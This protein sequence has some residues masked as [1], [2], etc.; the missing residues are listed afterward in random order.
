MLLN[1]TLFEI[2]YGFRRAQTYIFFTILFLLTFLFMTTDIIQIG[3][4]TGK[5]MKNAP[6]VI[7]QTVMIM[8]I[9]GMTMTSGLVG[10]AVLRDFEFK[11]HELLYTTP[12]KKTD[13][14]VGRFLGAYCVSLFVYSGIVFGIVLGSFMPWL[15]ADKIAPFRFDAYTQPFINYVIPNVFFASAL[16][17]MVGIF[18][19]NMLAVY[20]QGMVLL[21]GYTIS[22][23]LLSDIQN[24]TIVNFSDPFGIAATRLVTRYWTVIEQNSLVMPLSGDFLYNRLVW[25]GVGVLLFIA[26]LYAFEYSAKPLQFWIRKPKSS[27]ANASANDEERDEKFTPLSIPKAA[28]NE[29]FG[30]RVQQFLSQVKFH[31]LA[32]VKGR[33]F[34]IICLIAMLNLGANAWSAD[35]FFGTTVYPLT[36]IMMDVLVANVL[37]LLI[38]VMSIST[39]EVVW[40]ERNINI[41]QTTDALNIP[42][43]MAM[44]SKICSVILAQI[45]VCVVIVLAGML[46]QTL[47]GYTNY[48]ILLYA[49]FIVMQV[50]P[51]LVQ[52]T[53]LAFF[54]Q[55]II[56]NKFVANIVAVLVFISIPVMAGGLRWNHNLYL[57]GGSPEFLYSDMNG[58]GHWLAPTFWFGLYWTG[59]ALLL[60]C[61]AY[62]F[63]MRGTAS[64]WQERLQ[65]ARSRITPRFSALAASILVVTL[66]TGGYIF[67]NTNILNAYKT[68]N[69][70]R[71]LSAEFEKKY[72]RYEGA[73][74]P[75]I[76]GAKMN[77]EIFPETRIVIANGEYTLVNKTERPI[78]SLYVQ[79]IGDNAIKVLSLTPSRANTLVLGDTASASGAFRIYKLQEPLQPNDTMR[80]AFTMKHEERGFQNSGS[81]TNIVNNGTF[82]NSFAFPHIGYTSDLEIGDEDERKKEGLAPRPRMASIDDPKARMNTYIS[83][84]ADW[85]TFE[86]T[87]STSPDQIAIA[88][89]YLQKEWQEN[90]RRYFQ[91]CMDATIL[92]F[93]SFLSAR[94]EIAKDV[95]KDPQ[96]KQQDVAIEIYYH[97]GH[98]YN[99]Q[100]MIDGVKKSLTYYTKNF[101][102][103]QHRQMRILEFP[104]YDRFAQ[105][106]PNTIP[107]SEAIGFIARVNDPEEDIDY[108]FYVTAHEVGH[109][110][111]AHQVIGANVQGATLMSESLAEY[112]AL[113]VMEH[114]Y[115]R[116]VMQKFLRYDLDRYLRGRSTEQIK[117]Q[118]LMFAENQAYIHYNKGSLVMY[119]LKDYIGEDSLNAALARYI[120]K[121]AFQNAPYTTAREFVAEI[122]T[123]VPDSLQ[124]MVSDMF[125]KITLYENRTEDASVK[126]L[127]NGK[128]QVKLTINAKKVHADSLG[129]EAAQPLKDWIDVGIFAKKDAGKDAGKDT[130]KNASVASKSGSS[131]ALGKPLYFKKH[132]ISQAQTR[133]EITVDEEPFKVGIDP[134][135]KLID[136]TPK[137]NVRD[138]K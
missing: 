54:V 32:L 5:I 23:T 41:A 10:S 106:F 61:G 18:T 95:W 79:A 39:G 121:T 80:L 46:V 113:M 57:F 9:I 64:S 122:R 138:V 87:V 75:R 34:Q 77:V 104:R 93:Y 55:A 105:S 109:Q 132:Y 100:R 47:K 128:Y 28:L 11:T 82:F 91:Y 73:A 65:T 25:V 48:E 117:E 43:G 22:R 83:Q 58:F 26:G 135:N 66:L 136:R 70:L 42:H 133:L 99:I 72:K 116:D 50:L 97:K 101:S 71:A 21:V 40:R 8:T 1:I 19:R 102:P 31:T 27:S 2:K 98:E 15:E 45:L 118:P 63:W 131:F 53:L 37:V 112:S 85:I 78:D 16:F 76:V 74:Q 124:Y 94:Y 36:Y 111:W 125:E 52:Y 29:H 134:Y 90:G 33:S 126:K 6:F 17:L 38:A 62:L 86:A 3:G 67:Y 56:N 20:V 123:V 88:P 24:D 114:E 60:G 81:S 30:A 130:S 84:E 35:S 44:V 107:Y 103:Y 49:K 4:A 51:M 7:N 115:G 12:L 13:Y 119:A 108:P 68:P 59:V 127:P 69:Q 120:K 89:G 96:G 137:D 14:V 129:N 110:W 92:N